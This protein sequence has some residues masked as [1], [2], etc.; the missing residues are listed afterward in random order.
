MCGVNP[1]RT[2]SYLACLLLYG[3]T[4]LAPRNTPELFTAFSRQHHARNA[5]AAQA[6]LCKLTTGN[7]LRYTDT[8]HCLT[9]RSGGR[10][11]YQKG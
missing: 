6:A 8:K 9:K 10:T 3:F 4:E 11:R 1:F 5:N 2:E 7:H